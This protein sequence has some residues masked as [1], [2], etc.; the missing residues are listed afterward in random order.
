MKNNIFYVYVFSLI[1]F[2]A[3]TSCKKKEEVESTTSPTKKNAELVVYIKTLLGSSGE[4]P[5]KDVK[6]KLYA[7]ETDRIAEAA[8]V[9][10]KTTD[11]LGTVHFYQ[12]EKEEYFLKI[13]HLQKGILLKTVST[14][15]KSTAYNTYVYP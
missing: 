11:S 13:V 4:I 7:N 8:L 1:L 10:E 14:P 12:L 3:Y 2:V 5:L 9:Q 6:V 15:D